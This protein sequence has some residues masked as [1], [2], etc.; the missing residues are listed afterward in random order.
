LYEA[1]N[2]V[3]AAFGVTSIALALGHFCLGLSAPICRKGAARVNLF[4]ELTGLVTPDIVGALCV[5]L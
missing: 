3:A 5:A 1:S 4:L 2:D